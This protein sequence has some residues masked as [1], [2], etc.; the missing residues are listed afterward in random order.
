MNHGSSVHDVASRL[1]VVSAGALVDRQREIP[2]RAVVSS[3]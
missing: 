3:S 2:G 1:I